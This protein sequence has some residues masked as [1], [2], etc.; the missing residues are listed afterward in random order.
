MAINVI[1][2]TLFADCLFFFF[3]FFLKTRIINSDFTASAPLPFE[4]RA[5][6][7][8]STNYAGSPSS[9]RA[10]MR[11]LLDSAS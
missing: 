1:C 4:E 9:Q 3:F 11:D 7:P 8:C 2:Q 10:A 5:P 6:T